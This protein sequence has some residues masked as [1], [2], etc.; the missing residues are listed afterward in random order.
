MYAVLLAI[1]WASTLVLGAKVNAP[2]HVRLAHPWL[3]NTDGTAAT[4]VEMVEAAADLWPNDILGIVDAI[5][6]PHKRTVPL[7]TS[8]EEMYG[9]VE[10]IMEYRLIAKMEFPDAMTNLDEWRMSVAQH[11]LAPRVAAFVQSYETTVSQEPECSTWIYWQGKALCPSEVSRIADEAPSAQPIDN[12]HENL[13]VFDHVFGRSGAPVAVLYADPTS[14]E[15]GNVLHSLFDIMDDVPINIVLRWNIPKGASGKHYVGGFGTSL[16]LKKVDYLVIDDRAVM[17]GDALFNISTPKSND[18]QWLTKH[19]GSKTKATAD[20]AQGAI[21]SQAAL[22]ENQFGLLGYGAAHAVLKSS[23]PLRALLQLTSEFPIHAADLADYSHKVKVGDEIFGELD[24]LHLSE[25]KPGTSKIWVNGLALPENEFVPEYLGDIIRK[26]RKLIEALTRDTIGFER[27]DAITL[28]MYEALSM[29]YHGASHVVQHYDASDRLEPG[30]IYYLNDVEANA[31]DPRFSRSLKALNSK[32]TKNPKILARNLHNVILIPDL[33]RRESLEHVG[34]MMAI[35]ANPQ[36]IRFGVVPMGD[37]EPTA[38]L[39][40]A[41]DNLGI[42]ELGDFLQKAADNLGGMRKLLGSFIPHV[43]RSKEV[44]EFLS[45]GA[46]SP[47]IQERMENIRAYLKRLDI[48][49]GEAYGTVFMDGLMMPFSQHTFT[50]A[51]MVLAQQEVLVTEQLKEGKITDSDDVTNFFYDLPNTIRAR[52]RLVVPRGSTGEVKST[53]VDLLVA[54]EACTAPDAPAVLRD[55]MYNSGHADMSIRIVADLESKQGKKLTELVLQAFDATSNWRVGFVH[56]GHAG[57]FSRLVYSAARS[58]R[59]EWL[60]AKD[61][62]QVLHNKESAEAVAAKAKFQLKRAEDADIFWSNVGPQF[63]RAANINGPSIII[64]GIALSFDPS[65][66]SVQDIRAVV[67]MESQS[68]ASVLVESVDLRGIQRTKRSTSIELLSSVLAMATEPNPA[69]EGI[70]YRESQIR[71]RVPEEL[72]KK[73]IAFRAGSSEAETSVHFTVLVDPLSDNAPATASTIRMLSNLRGVAVTVV[74]NPSPQLKA[75]PLQKFARYEMPTHAEFENG[76]R[77][78]PTISFAELPQS[79]VLTMEMHAPHG[80]VAMASE[81]VYDLDNIRLADVPSDARLYGVEALYEAR[82]LLF[83]GHGRE[84]DGSVVRGI[85][86]ELESADGKV[87]YDTIQMENLGYFQFRVPPGRWNLRVRDGESAEKYSLVSTGARG[88]DSPTIN[89]TGPS[90]SVD[91]LRGSVIYPQFDVDEDVNTA[92]RHAQTSLSR[93][94]HAD[95]NIFTVASGHLYERMTYIM[96]LSV[97]RH[98]KHSVKFWFIENFLSPAFKGLIPHLAKEYNFEY[99]MVT[100]AWPHWLRGQTEKQRLIWA[101]KILFLDVLFPLD[102]DR[103]IFVDA[104]QIVRHDMYDLV[105]MDLDGA[106]YGYPPMGDDS[107]DMDG[108]RFWKKGYWA[109]FLRGLTYHISALYVVDLQRFREMGAGDLLRKHYQQ[110]SADPK[111]LANLDQDLPNH[112]QHSLPIFTLDKT[113]L[114]C[115]TWCSHDWLSEAKTIDLCSNPKTKEPKLDRAR[116]QIPEWNELDAEVA[117]LARRVASSREA[118]AGNEESQESAES[119]PVV[120]HD[121][122]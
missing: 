113:W 65:L 73:K 58:G 17:E 40:Y 112:L 27:E 22:T 47:Q 53:A 81:A 21:K 110:L 57:D 5:W 83:E 88:W 7:D 96:I 105:Q 49:P 15:V 76:V 108:F 51:G 9:Q 84:S 14:H 48:Q 103:V 117:Q 82:D 43:E 97:L 64:N 79:A 62:L 16:H 32:N 111:S 13:L 36:M 122:L 20:A 71:S 55:F 86:L 75:L 1:F 72:G 101:Y 85:E 63:V 121:E 56:T 24:Q 92:S 115:E 8:D 100:Y 95:I 67:D 93:S 87:R 4:L 80:M 77:V 41:F 37:D 44:D 33:S 28:L 60:S 90:V 10:R 118:Q 39:L 11:R 114:W 30:A 6:G 46:V 54:M 120:V 23:D 50:P 61:L 66:V 18:R 74:L 42:M 26:E 34:A 89:V 59:L 78:P 2:V 29:A 99:E 12:V 98:T 107:E 3:S 94:R 104:D 25:L 119:E 91:T 45:T 109:K 106:P 102:L 68:H 116:R 38:T 31:G 19:L 52:T 70:F 69:A 35:F